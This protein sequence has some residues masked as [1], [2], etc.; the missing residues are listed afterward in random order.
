MS[1]NFKKQGFATRAIH[2]GYDSREHQGALVPPVFLS[3]TFTFETA[4]KGGR[5]FSGEDPDY[6]YTRIGNPTLALFESRM[7]CLEGGHSAVAFGSGM[8]AIASTLWTLLRPGDEIIVDRTM[9]GCTFSFLH[10]GIGLFGV[11]VSHVDL[12]D[13]KNLKDVISAKTKV[14]YLETPVNPTMSLVD[15]AAV[16][17]IAHQHGAKVVVD[18]TY[19]SPYLQQ[20]LALGA[21]VVVHSATKYIGGHGDVTA[22]VAVMAEPETALQIRM[23][24][25]KDLTGA[26]LSPQDAYLLLRGLKTLELRLDRH[27]NNA[28]V[29]AELLVAHP[30]V[31]TV[32]F[33]GLPSFP[34][35]ALA[36]SQMR[37]F[38]G[39]LAFEL[40]GGACAGKKFLNA[41]QMISRA[42][43]LGDAESLAQHPASMTHSTYTQQEREAAGISD[44]LVRLSV[45][46]ET[47][48][49]LKDDLSQALDSLL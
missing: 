28:E 47:V 4:E 34:Q 7:A 12:R 9:Y 6:F 11:I 15:I 39:I 19:C 24:G 46:L 1:V 3:S 22:G 14:V 10:H 18:N 2:H 37:R 23:Q 30:A 36:Q 29:I 38:G 32:H 42:V 48:Q 27:C 5:C 35:Y 49:D 8:G 45:G 31:Q 44:G 20:P 43:S 40:V 25:L 41:L 21:D 17:E 26:V 16:A 13:P 33:P